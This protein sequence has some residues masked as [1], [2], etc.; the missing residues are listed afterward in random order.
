VR[1]LSCEDILTECENVRAA[2]LAATRCEGTVRRTATAGPSRVHDRV[3][4]KTG[5]RAGG[6]YIYRTFPSARP[7][8]Q[9]TH[10]AFHDAQTALPNRSLVAERWT[11][12]AGPRRNDYQY[13]CS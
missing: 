12:P 7:S 9:I 4:V 1:A 10:Q 3:S 13:A 2:I 5:M 11:G 8:E 6:V